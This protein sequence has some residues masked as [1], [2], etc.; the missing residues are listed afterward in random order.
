[1][2]KHMKYDPKISSDGLWGLG[3]DGSIVL[4]ETLKK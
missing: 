1:M 2:I 4:Q 3:V